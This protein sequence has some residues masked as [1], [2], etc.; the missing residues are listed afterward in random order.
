MK[1]F[2]C[3]LV[4]LSLFLSVSHGC[5]LVRFPVCG[6]DGQTYHNDCYLNIA[7]SR[8]LES[9]PDAQPITVAYMGECGKPLKPLPGDD[10]NA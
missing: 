5:Y 4:V 10:F 2:L 1:V 8:L 3:L 7:N 6:T 9:T